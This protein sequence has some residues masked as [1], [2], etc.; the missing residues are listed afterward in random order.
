M[1]PYVS[2]MLYVRRQ[3]HCYTSSYMSIFCFVYIIFSRPLLYLL[4]VYFILLVCLKLKSFLYVLEPF[5]DY[6]NWKKCFVPVVKILQQ[7]L[8][9][10][11][12]KFFMPLNILRVCVLSKWFWKTENNKQITNV[13]AKKWITLNCVW[14]GVYR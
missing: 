5:T 10:L 6:E 2:Y 4:Y 13:N 9:A 1:I 7:F 8:S 3:T 12:Y 14:Y 11:V